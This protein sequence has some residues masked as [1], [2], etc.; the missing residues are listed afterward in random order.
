M[1][2]LP[3]T[4]PSLPQDDTRR[5]LSPAES[6]QNAERNQAGRKDHSPNTT[7]RLGVISR[8][9]EA[10][11]EPGHGDTRKRAEENADE[12]RQPQAGKPEIGRTQAEPDQ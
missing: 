1:G 4:L 3:P 8:S 12:M 9:L 5:S 6:N 7:A 10:L 2:T 11:S